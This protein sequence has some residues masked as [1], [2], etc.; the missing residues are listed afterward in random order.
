M[1]KDVSNA[2]ILEFLQEHMVMREEFVSLQ[3]EFGLMR[4]EFN[5]KLSKQ[6]HELMDFVER[7]FESFEG[8]FMYLVRILEK[9]TILTTMERKTVCSL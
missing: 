2:E 1:N 5:G 7:K 4:E 9:K 6:K 8:K 3:K